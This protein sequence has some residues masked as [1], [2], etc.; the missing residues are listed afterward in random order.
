MLERSVKGGSPTAV[1]GRLTRRLGAPS[2]TQNIAPF[3]PGA[4]STA[5]KKRD[6]PRKTIP[7]RRKE[8]SQVLVQYCTPVRGMHC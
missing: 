2:T 3:L 6:N 1:D 8:I 4:D 7:R 5:R